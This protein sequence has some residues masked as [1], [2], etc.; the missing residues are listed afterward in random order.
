MKDQKSIFNDI[1]GPVMRG[2]SSS[3]TAASWRIARMAIQILNEPLKQALVEFDKEGAWAPNFREQGTTIGIEGGLLEL[4]IT[5]SRMKDTADLFKER[6]I[7]IEYLV[8]SFKT[9]HPNT[10]RLSLWG[11]SKKKTQIT[12]VSLGGGSFE[13]TAINDFSVQMQG[14]FYEMIIYTKK[15]PDIQEDIKD[16]LP[17]KTLSSLHEGP[18]SYML[19]IKSS[20][21]FS[22]ELTAQLR[23]T[24]AVEGL[25]VI[26]PV[27]PVISGRQGDLPFSSLP[28]LVKY[29]V[30]ENSSLGDIGLLYEKCRSGLEEKELFAKM[31]EII[32]IVHAGIDTGLKGTL[33]QD[34]ILHQQSHLIGKAE[35]AGKLKSSVTNRIIENV[36]ALMEMKSAMEVIVAAPT[37]GSCGTLGGSLRA[38]GEELG[39][40]KEEMIKAYFAAGIVGVY[41]ASGP[42]FSAEEHGCQVECGAASGMAAAGIT[43]LMG[44][45]AVEAVAAASMAIQNMIGLICDPVADRVEVPCLGKNISAAV[46]A[47]SSALMA[48]S[49]FDPVIPLEETILTVSNVGKD[50]PACVKCTGKGGLAITETALRIKKNLENT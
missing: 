43:Q 4:D 39:S 20:L 44:G 48:V 12:A 28:S 36:S 14:D 2:P 42:G 38:V 26:D 16:L 24:A 15:D 23:E 22:R 3:H 49:G 10:V 32:Q 35:K 5:D 8:S 27:M 18:D 6:N 45:S 41:F 13:I 17:P 50:M 34:R 21:P 11:K 47:Y 40:S 37:A 46:N 7:E 31:D 30:K 25:M 33:Y 9:N 29:A 1:I 19:Q